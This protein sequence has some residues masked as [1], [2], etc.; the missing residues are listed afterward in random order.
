MNSYSGDG[1]TDERHAQALAIRK[2]FDQGHV[3]IVA[4][5]RDLLS[6]G[7]VTPRALFDTIGFVDLARY[8]SPA[9]CARALEAA[10]EAG[11]NGGAFADQALLDVVTPDALARALPLELLSDVIVALTSRIEPTLLQM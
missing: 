4:T 2:R 7:L 6:V 1:H 3:T 11:R 9:T 8:L 10:V 5:L